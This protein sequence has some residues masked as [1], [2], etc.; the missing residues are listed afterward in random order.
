MKSKYYRDYFAQ[1]YANNF[2]NLANINYE[3]SDQ[4]RQKI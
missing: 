1:L 3:N 4:E 2:E